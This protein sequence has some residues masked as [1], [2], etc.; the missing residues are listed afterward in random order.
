MMIPEDHKS[1]L[2]HTVTINGPESKRRGTVKALQDAG[3]II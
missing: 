3:I 1:E 2:G